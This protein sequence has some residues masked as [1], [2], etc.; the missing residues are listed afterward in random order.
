MKILFFSSYFYPYIS[1]LTIYPWRILNHLSKKHKITVLTFN[2]SKDLLKTK[3]YKLKIFYLPYLLRVSKGFISPQSIFYFI[4]EAVKNDIVILNIPNF[5]GLFLA[6]IAKILGKKILTIFHCQVF[7][8]K[9]FF[10]KIIEFFLNLSINVQLSLSNKIV[11]YTND[12][13]ESLKIGQRFLKKT[14]CTLPPID[15]LNID[16]N[17]LKHLVNL[18]SNQLWIGYSGR[19]AKEKG[20]EYLIEAFSEIKSVDKMLVFAGPYRNEVVGE[21]AYYFKIKK[22]L[23]NKKISH[24]FFGNLDIHKLGAFYKM[25][26]ILVLPSI[27]QTEAFGMVQAEAMLL[28]TPVIASNLPGVRVPI[29]L[30]KMGLLVEPKNSKQLIEA[31]I[32][33]L[34]NKNGFVNADLVEKAKKIFDVKKTYKF[35]DDFV[36]CANPISKLRCL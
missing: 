15:Q 31:I 10:N 33:I 29:K 20:L 17:E 8:P 1:G 28:G 4:V 3:N 22:L 21:N 26:D 9:N 36:G 23:E 24:H 7:L 5:E 11:I 35:Y 18:K 6:T 25:I 2:H 27:N 12:Y 13:F 30:T 19:I 34:K 14:V 32:A 16:K